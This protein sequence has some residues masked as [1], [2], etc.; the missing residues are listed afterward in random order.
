MDINDS[1]LIFI[2]LFQL[3][4]SVHRFTTFYSSQHSGRKLNWLYNM[5]KGELHTNCFKNRY[6]LQ[7]ST[8][9][10]AVL[11]QYNAATSWTIQQ[12]HDA[13]QIKMDFLLQ[14]IQILLK[15][16]LLTAPV[17]DEAELT[18]MSSVELFTGYKK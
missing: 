7:A 18:P 4:R 17:D 11:L 8:F 12:L 15:A 2:L 16:K 6:T 14:V 13:T 9:Q 5:S 10:M 3:E 1:L